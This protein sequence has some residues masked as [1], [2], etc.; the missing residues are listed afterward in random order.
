MSEDDPNL[1]PEDFDNNDQSD[2]NQSGP[3][4]DD[5]RNVFDMFV[6]DLF[7]AQEGEPPRREW[8]GITPGE[9]NDWYETYLNSTREAEKL[10]K[11]GVSSEAPTFLEIL[12]DYLKK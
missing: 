9:I 4:K 10:G 8:A 1:N 7:H 5:S 12:E 11:L 6:D 3:N 2:E